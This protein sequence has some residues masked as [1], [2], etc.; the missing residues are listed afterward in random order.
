MSTWCE[1]IE[2]LTACLRQATA[3]DRHGQIQ[4]PDAAFARWEEWTVEARAARRL[5]YFIGNGASAS[6]ACHLA[7]DLRKNAHV[8]TEVLTDPALLTAL[9]ND[10]AYDEVFAEPIRRAMNA[11]DLLI[12]ISSSGR[13]PNILKA[14]AAAELRGGRVIT[15]SAMRPENPLRRAGDLNWYVP[16]ETY[17]LAESAHAALLHHW[18]DRM[19]AHTPPDA[20]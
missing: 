11:G 14:A 2:R 4:D 12:A 19:A 13:S 10:L 9:A 3:T 1:T 7:A 8:H 17:G 5:A 20:S 18:M 16:A 6:M 15:L